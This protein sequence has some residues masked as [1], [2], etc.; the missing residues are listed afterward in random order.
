MDG[1]G[2]DR[3]ADDRRFPDRE[4]AYPSAGGRSRRKGTANGST[5]WLGE[6]HRIAGSLRAR[7]ADIRQCRTDSIARKDL[8]GHKQKDVTT[9]YSAAEL[10][11]LLEA[12]NRVVRSKT[13]EESRKTPALT[14]LRLVA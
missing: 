2:S 13:E 14:V 4:R 11:R 10:A 1:A 9:D 3:T 8:L 7:S 12:A 6:S 5:C